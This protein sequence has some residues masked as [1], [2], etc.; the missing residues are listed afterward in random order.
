M[1]AAQWNSS[2]ARQEFITSAQ[3]VL[4]AQADQLQDQQEDLRADIETA[5]D[6]LL[7]FQEADA[8]SQAT[9]G[10]LN[11][12]LAAARLA[13]GQTEVIGPGMV[14][15]I[16]DSL[17]PGTGDDRQ[18]DYVVVDDLRDIVT[19]LWG[20][21]AE[22]I[23][24]AG[25]GGG[26]VPAERI[27]ASTSIDGAGPA[28]LVNSTRLSPPYR[29]EAIGPEGL[30]ERFL[31]HPAYLA[32]VEATDH[33]LRTAVRLGGPRRDRPARVRREHPA[34][35]GRARRRG[36]ELMA[37]RIA[38]LSLFVVALIIGVL[39]VGQL[40][41]QARPIELSN[42]TPQELSALIDTLSARNVELRD[43]LADLNEQVRNYE[44]AEV[45]GQSTL[46]LTEEELYRIEAFGGLRA[47]EG[48]GVV[49]R[50]EGTLD[51]TAVN[52]L[53]YEL[54]GAGAEAIAVD[55][56]RITARSVAVQGA[57]AIEIDG[58]PLGAT[59]EILAIGSPAGL[60]AA[61]ERPG[62]VLTLL[63][64]AIGLQYEI[65]QQTEMEV[66][67]TGRDLEPQAARSVE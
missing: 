30:A 21:G 53:I 56:I 10:L 29:I 44:L 27:V 12:Q 34:A 35:M 47:V 65:E 8:G 45:Q 54:R 46:S 42:L 28:I 33:R 48:Q 62:G 38:Q 49:L 23:T 15:E 37:R 59:I 25:G 58:L 5:N 66:P 6:R 43:A 63:Q 40:R 39:L 13:S 52:D 31:A 7:T 3:R 67:A 50:V 36:A 60:E 57:G 61:L 32:R 17:N 20:A 2:L 9:L 19:A 11:E 24:V 14:I 1:G 18:I 51:P 55:D 64:Q 41:S 22:A 4:I 26:G 16:A